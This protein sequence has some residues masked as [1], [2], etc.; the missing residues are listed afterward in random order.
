MERS[1]KYADGRDIRLGDRVRLGQDDRGVV[2]A[3]IDTGE[4]SSGFPATSWGH[5]KQGVMINF[6]MY[7]L[8]HYEEAEED[9]ELIERG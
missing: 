7:G 8:I 3:S 5:L 1:M 6:P 9:L 2:V 4:Y